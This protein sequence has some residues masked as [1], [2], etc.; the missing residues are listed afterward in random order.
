[1]AAVKTG[2]GPCTNIWVV[3]GNLMINAR[4]YFAPVGSVDFASPLKP[5]QPSQVRRSLTGSFSG[6]ISDEELNHSFTAM[7]QSSSSTSHPA[8]A[9]NLSTHNPIQGDDAGVGIYFIKNENDGRFYVKQLMPGYSAEMCGSIQTGDIVTHVGFL[10]LP[11]ELT[12]EDLRPLIVSSLA[13]TST[14]LLL[15]MSLIRQVG[16]AGTSVNL[17]FQRGRESDESYGFYQV[18]LVRG[19]SQTNPSTSFPASSPTS[20]SRGFQLVAQGMGDQLQRLTNHKIFQAGRSH[21]HRAAV[22]LDHGSQSAASLPAN[23]TATPARSSALA[24]QPIS[25]LSSSDEATALLDVLERLLRDSLARSQQG[26]F[27]TILRDFDSCVIKR[28]SDA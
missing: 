7:R 21:E 15:P 24:P 13:R 27:L 28:S 1:M 6:P 5:R 18:K 19:L 17:T 10:K 12:L 2:L 9:G 14:Y 23:I 3:G 25:G 26:K 16:R 4:N 20:A 11:S 22:S 8:S